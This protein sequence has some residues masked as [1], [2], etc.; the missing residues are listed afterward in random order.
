[1]REQKLEHVCLCND[2]ID[3]V[4]QPECTEL[5]QVRYKITCMQLSRPYVFSA[6]TGLAEAVVERGYPEQGLL[7][8]HPQRITGICSHS[9]SG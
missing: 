2:K 9:C 4:D 7:K 5:L 8:A 1:M 3:F 6:Q